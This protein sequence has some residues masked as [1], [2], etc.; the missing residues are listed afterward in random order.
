MQTSKNI[1]IRLKEVGFILN[2]KKR[3]WQPYNNGT[4]GYYSYTVNTLL[5]WLRDWSES[6]NEKSFELQPDGI[7]VWNWKME[8]MGEDFNYFSEYKT[9]YAD[10]I[11][12]AIIKIMEEKII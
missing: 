12:K 2:H 1:S 3:I 11:G 8:V 5:E 7:A 6:E 4:G 9:N 10:C